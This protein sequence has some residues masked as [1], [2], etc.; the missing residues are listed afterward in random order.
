MERGDGER[1]W[2]EEMERGDGERRWR[3]EM[4][5]GGLTDQTEGMW[6]ESRKAAHKTQKA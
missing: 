4:E 5:R 2:R 6:R 3:E 1:R